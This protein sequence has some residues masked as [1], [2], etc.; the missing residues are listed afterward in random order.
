MR[1]RLRYLNQSFN[2]IILR[3]LGFIPFTILFQPMPVISIQPGS[4]RTCPGWRRSRMKSIP[5][6]VRT[7]WWSIWLWTAD[8]IYLINIACATRH[9]WPIF[10]TE[11]ARFA[12]QRCYICWEEQS[13]TKSSLQCLML[14]KLVCL[15]HFL[16]ELKK[17]FHGESNASR[18]AMSYPCPGYDVKLNRAVLHLLSSLS[19]SLRRSLAPLRYW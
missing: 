4:P 12:R 7:A 15:T 18:Y 16:Y 10:F 6:M 1:H 13:N 9:L 5:G 2:S 17:I 8:I 19:S 3:W 14:T 11:N